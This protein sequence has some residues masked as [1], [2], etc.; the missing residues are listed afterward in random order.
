MFVTHEPFKSPF[1]FQLPGGST[2][3]H[4]VELMLHTPW[5]LIT[6]E[7]EEEEDAIRTYFLSG[8]DVLLQLLNNPTLGKTKGVQLVLPPGWSPTREWCFVRI[9]RVERELRSATGAVLSSVITSVGGQ[10]FGG[11]P[12]EPTVRED[13][14]LALILELPVADG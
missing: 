10:R 12:I 5:L 2:T 11:F 8:T 4:V 3:W 7:D 13:S 1:P 9:R 6:V 14:D